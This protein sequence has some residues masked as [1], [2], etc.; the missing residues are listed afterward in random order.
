MESKA[1]HALSLK[2][3]NMKKQTGVFANMLVYKPSDY[4][5]LEMGTHLKN[6]N[7]PLL[8]LQ[9]REFVIGQFRHILKH[10]GLTEQQ[11]RIIRTL[12][13]QDAME[14]WQLCEQC[15]ILS[16]S[17][18]GVLTRMEETGLIVRSP[19]DGD[20]RRILISLSADSQALV[21]T[22][23]PLI[24]LQYQNLESGLGRPAIEELY[25]VLDRFLA[26]KNTLI[27]QI[28]L[29][30]HNKPRKKKIISKT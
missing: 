1:R 27:A 25:A 7:L 4:R 21:K 8:L 11:W 9:A 3:R 10:Y 20:Q 17:L 13:E 26:K 23:A 16:P 6:R 5:T 19:F 2:L 22:I 15:Q 24:E 18:A 30:K 29:P 12:S 28:D 14:P